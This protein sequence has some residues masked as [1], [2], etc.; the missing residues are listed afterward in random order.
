M[1]DV[2]VRKFVPKPGTL[3][4]DVPAS[5]SILNRALLLS[6]LAKGD[7]T[8]HAGALG[9][10]AKA[11]LRCIE[12]LGVQC[13]KVE[14]GILVHGC[15]GKFREGASLD[16]GSAGTVARFFP[17]AL[18]FAGGNYRFDA[19]AQMKAR[20]MGI[21][22]LLE[23]V[24][25]KFIFEEAPY[26][27]P[28]TMTSEGISAD[29]LVVDT[30]ESTQYA[31]ALMMAAS[32]RTSP[33]TLLLTGPRIKGSYVKIT[34]EMLKSFH[35]RT[36]DVEGGV[37]VFPAGEPPKEFDVEPDISGACY[38]YA[39][40]LL[41][42]ARV[43]VPRAHLNTAQG[44]IRF[45]HVL[46]DKGVRL[47]ETP[48]GLIADG[49]N[50]P[51]FNGFDYDMQDFS[52]QA[53]TVAALGLFATSPSILRNIAHIRHQECDRIAAIVENANALGARCFT[54]GTDVFL[55]PAPVHPTRIHSFGDHRVAMAFALVGMKLGG[56]TVDD[57]DCAAKSF[58]GYFELLDSLPRANG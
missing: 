39:L 56:V 30:T 12:A 42:G 4:V 47:T 16:V 1:Q 58:E 29:E 8:L 40:S 53:L 24:G 13:E 36:E 23:S 3:V 22:K 5:K 27:F 37:K 32:V 35:I 2:L 15:G 43:Q 57:P 45:L 31:S 19:S 48:E 26:S 7:V 28:F 38:L 25:V 46:E 20:P 11:A 17:A 9:E 6:A 55:E 49:K 34:R 21:L 18:A 44:D 10:D 41:C 33:T 54:D 52:D 14:G 51:F 50:V